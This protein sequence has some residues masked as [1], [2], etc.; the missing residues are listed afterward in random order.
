M[1][2]YLS[3]DLCGDDPA[4][5]REI[6]LNGW[7]ANLIVCRVCLEADDKEN[8]FKDLKLAQEARE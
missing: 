7:T 6:D 3:C 4:Q 2:N 5:L 8:D 1:T